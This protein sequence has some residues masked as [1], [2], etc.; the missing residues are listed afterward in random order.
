MTVPSQR[1]S[2]VLSKIGNNY[3]I[4]QIIIHWHIRPKCKSARGFGERPI[5]E[6]QGI[7]DDVHERGMTRCDLLQFFSKPTLD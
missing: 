2:N 4:I 1:S 5:S 7:S 6:D 3:C